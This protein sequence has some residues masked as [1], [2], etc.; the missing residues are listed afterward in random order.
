MWCDAA[1]Q[2]AA[3]LVQAGAAVRLELVAC[4]ELGTGE[5]SVATSWAA[6]LV[7]ACSGR[8]EATVA[9]LLRS[10][11][12]CE[13][14]RGRVAALLDLVGTMVARGMDPQD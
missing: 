6:A 8:D 1:V 4:D 3:V 11:Q 13:Q 12:S 9:V 2:A 5:V 10:A 7:T 14:M